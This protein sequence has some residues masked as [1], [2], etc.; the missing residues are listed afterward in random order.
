M[1][2]SG[3][4]STGAVAEHVAKHYNAMRGVGQYK[5]H[6]SVIY[7]VRNFNNWIKSVLINRTSTCLLQGTSFA[8]SMRHMPCAPE[9]NQGT[10]NRDR[11][12]R[13]LDL[14][15]GKG[16]DLKKWLNVDHYVGQIAYYVGLDVADQS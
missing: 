8:E 13:V 11:V 3:G 5:R 6:Q 12:L 10:R 16:G 7:G 2:S 1:L 4:P 14:C 9:N 15:C